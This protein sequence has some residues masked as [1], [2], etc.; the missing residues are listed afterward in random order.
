MKHILGMVMVGV[1]AGCATAGSDRASFPDPGR[2]YPS[3]GTFI[4]LDDLRQYGEGMNKRQLQAL[5]GTPH[6]NEGMWGVR[7]WNYLFNLRAAPGASAVRCQF[8]VQFDAAGVATGHAWQPTSCGA[9]LEPP[10]APAPPQATTGKAPLRISADTLFAFDSATLS[11]SGRQAL[12]QALQ[13]KL[14]GTVQLQVIGHTDR[15]GAADY[16][17]QLSRQRA[18]AVRQ[19]LVQEMGV[20]ASAVSAQGKGMAEPV[21][22]CQDGPRQALVDCLAPNR[23]VDIVGISS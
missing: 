5:L 22:E 16:N 2:A 13:G 17:M 21:V 1:L 15:I 19:F 14:D 3:G 7:E 6:F 11:D 9:L 4:N 23:R 8:Q 18:E 10:P 20:A 12:R